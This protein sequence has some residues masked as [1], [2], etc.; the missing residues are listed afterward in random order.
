MW[1]PAGP[2]IFDLHLGTV[3]VAAAGPRLCRRSWSACE[4]RPAEPRPRLRRVVPGLP[5]RWPDTPGGINCP[6][7]FLLHKSA[8]AGLRAT[9]PLGLWARGTNCSPPPIPMRSITVRF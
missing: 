8:E 5:G 4:N 3:C 6:F 7:A 2:A 9:R 1:V